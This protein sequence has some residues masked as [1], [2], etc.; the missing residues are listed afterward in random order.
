MRQRGSFYIPDTHPSTDGLG[1]SFGLWEMLFSL[2]SQLFQLHMDIDNPCVV[3]IVGRQSMC[4]WNSWE[5]RLNIQEITFKGPWPWER[6]NKIQTEEVMYK[7]IGLT[8]E[9]DK[10]KFI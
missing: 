2:V 9:V 1:F 8:E 5:T 4:G 10:L 6:R 3:G 7:E